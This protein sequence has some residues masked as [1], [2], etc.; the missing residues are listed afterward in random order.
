MAS[1]W[2]AGGTMSA[3]DHVIDLSTMAD[4]GLS[5]DD[6]PEEVPGVRVELINGSLIVTP[7]GDVEHQAIISR[8]CRLLQ[9]PDDLLVLAGVNVIV[10]GRTLIIPDLAVVDTLHME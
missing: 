2:S 8:F 10:G 6:L 4:G 7:L 9:P 3:A 1:H 5:I